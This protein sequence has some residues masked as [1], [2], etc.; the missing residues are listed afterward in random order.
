MCVE[1]YLLQE[2]K[3]LGVRK[4][5]RCHGF[6]ADSNRVG[7]FLIFSANKSYK[8]NARFYFTRQ[9]LCEQFIKYVE[10]V[11]KFKLIPRIN[12]EVHTRRIYLQCTY[13]SEFE[14]A[15]RRMYSFAIC[16]DCGSAGIIDH[17]ETVML[18]AVFSFW[19]TRSLSV[20]KKRAHAPLR[21]TTQKGI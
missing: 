20:P 8:A 6:R 9:V 7:T 21:P 12:S 17:V 15:L 19:H 2:E 18:D 4:K 16:F 5:R 10:H 11:L 1:G 3:K 14:V 13:I